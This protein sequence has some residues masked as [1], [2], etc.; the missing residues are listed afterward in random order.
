V[1]ISGGAGATGAGGAPGGAGGAGGGLNL[2][3]SAAS[4]TT[5][6]AAG[7]TIALTAVGSSAAPHILCGNGV[8][9]STTP[10]GSLY[11]RMD[12]GAGST[13]YVRESGAWVAK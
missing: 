10:N 3:G 9:A 8:P 2:S 13:L 7:G 1:I 5:P 6:G 12:G 4:G 11:L